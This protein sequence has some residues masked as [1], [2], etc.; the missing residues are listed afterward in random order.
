MNAT[1]CGFAFAIFASQ[2]VACTDLDLGG[3]AYFHDDFEG[4]DLTNWQRAGLG[5][6]GGVYAFSGGSVQLVTNQAHWGKGALQLTL[7]QVPG[8]LENAGVFR[9]WTTPQVAYF[10]AYMMFP[11][12][13]TVTGLWTI[14]QYRGQSTPL[15]AD[16]LYEIRMR[17]R[18]D[19]Q[20]EMGLFHG[21]SEIAGSFIDPVGPNPPV[22]LN[23]WL[24][25]EARVQRSEVAS[26]RLTFWRDGQ[27][28]FDVANM[29]TTLNGGKSMWFITSIG[30]DIV[31]GPVQHFV[32]DATITA[33]RWHPISQAP[34]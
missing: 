19:G 6:Q 29:K 22:P 20:L 16:V 4:N 1:A 10:A 14:F 21:S 28:L 5:T 26:G 18:T 24:H 31:P 33:V 2:L 17:N 13:H 9:E 11:R 12:T 15:D 30:A 34:Q 25:L 27:L 23:Q 8:R 7:E 3:G 32:D